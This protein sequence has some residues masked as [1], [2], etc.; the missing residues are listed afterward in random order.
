MERD[1]DIFERLPGASVPCLIRV[2]GTLHVPH[3]STERLGFLK[4]GHMSGR[5]YEYMGSAIASGALDWSN[6]L[7]Y[8]KEIVWS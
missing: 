2:H 4:N 1:Y 5:H 3:K 6:L 8:E 7:L